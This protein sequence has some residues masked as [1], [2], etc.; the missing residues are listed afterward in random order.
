MADHCQLAVAWFAAV[1]VAIASSHRSRARAKIGA[2]DIDQRFAKGRAAGLVTNERR[3]DVASLQEDPASDADCFLAFAD[4]DAPGDP[5]AAIHAGQFFFE[6]SR[7]QHPAKGLEIFFGSRRFRLGFLL[8]ARGLQHRTIVANIRSAAQKNFRR[9]M[10]TPKL[11]WGAQAASLPSPSACRRQ[12]WVS[13]I[14]FRKLFG[15]RHGTQACGLCAKRTFCPLS[16]SAAAECNSAG[17]TDLEV[18][19]PYQP[20]A[21]LEVAAA[22][23]A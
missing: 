1:N 21:R 4:V 16:N 6:C 23:V 19:V 15:E 8:R 10:R 14:R 5:T 18:Y 9:G 22:R 7:Q 20:K 11:I 3:E 13:T 2:C 17:R 12:T